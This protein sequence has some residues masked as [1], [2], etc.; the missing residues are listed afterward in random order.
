MSDT[1]GQLENFMK[2]VAG[3]R[4]ERKPVRS[5]IIEVSF[6]QAYWMNIPARM[7]DILAINQIKMIKEFVLVLYQNFVEDI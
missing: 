7:F 1:A 5:N 2:D 4:K 3:N 6:Q